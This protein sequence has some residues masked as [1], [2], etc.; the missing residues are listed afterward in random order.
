MGAFVTVQDGVALLIVAMAVAYL[1]RKMRG[2]K[3]TKH[4][5][6]VPLSRLKKGKRK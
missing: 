5:P 4:G 6:D 3:H 2:N 1:F